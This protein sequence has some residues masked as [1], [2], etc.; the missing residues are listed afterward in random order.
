MRIVRPDR[1]LVVALSEAAE[2]GRAIMADGFER[3]FSEALLTFAALDLEHAR[4]RSRSLASIG[5]SEAAP[6][7]RFERGQIDPELGEL[8]IEEGVAHRRIDAVVLGTGDVLHLLHP[9]LRTRDT[10]HARA[11][12]REQK[13]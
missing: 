10:G 11:L 6:F 4:F 5:A 9:A 1:M 3:Q 8:A 2:L 7:G 13:L 12:L